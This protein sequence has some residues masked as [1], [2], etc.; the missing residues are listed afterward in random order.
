MTHATA[1][2]ELSFNKGSIL[3]INAEED[4]NWFKAQQD[5]KDGLIPQ[6]YIEMKPHEWYY[7]RITRAKAEEILSG[8]P[9]MAPSS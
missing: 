3:V 9:M 6:N 5:G 8:Q 2:D 7:G 1:H 4:K